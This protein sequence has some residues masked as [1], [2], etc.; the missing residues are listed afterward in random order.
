MLRIVENNLSKLSSVPQV[1]GGP[2]G[3][4]PTSATGAASTDNALVRWGGSGGSSLKN[5]ALTLRESGEVRDSSG[6]ALFVEGEGLSVIVGTRVNMGLTGPQNYVGANSVAV[7]V[8]ALGS[9]SATGGN[10]V[11]VGKDALADNTSGSSNVAV[12]HSALTA[13]LSGASNTAVG[14]GTLISNTGGNYNSAVGDGALQVCRGSNNSAV[15]RNA[16]VALTA[17]T[18]NTALGAGALAEC[19]TGGTNTAVGHNAYNTGNY[20]NSI[21]LGYGAAVTASNQI[22]IGD[23]ALQA[24]AVTSTTGGAVIANKVAIK[25]GSTTYYLLAM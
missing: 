19:T 6:T 23:T 3:P 16:G 20:Q 11:A 24:V 8:G 12:G 5:S 10:N 14:S 21:A 7:G 2:H 17:A 13:N 4:I 15:G 9:G 1:A 18:G 25:I 22:V